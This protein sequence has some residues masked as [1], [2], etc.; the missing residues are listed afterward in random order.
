M[1]SKSFLTNKVQF[2]S[3]TIVTHLYVTGV[4][5]IVWSL[6]WSTLTIKCPKSVNKLRTT[7][8]K[9]ELYAQKR[10]LEKITRQDKK[11]EADD[12]RNV[13]ET[14]IIYC[15]FRSGQKAEKIPLFIAIEVN[16]ALPYVF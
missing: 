13:S 2:F 4:E 12:T 16:L 6:L 14:N 7:P 3:Y 10:L 8:K 11:T 5:D 15:M 1:Q 9:S